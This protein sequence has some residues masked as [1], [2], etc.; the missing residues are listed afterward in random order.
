[1]PSARRRR[2]NLPC[3]HGQQRI[4]SHSN[5]Q[6]TVY[7]MKYV[8]KTAKTGLNCRRLCQCFHCSHV[9]GDWPH[10]RPHEPRGAGRLFCEATRRR[11]RPTGPRVGPRD[12]GSRSLEVPRG[13]VVR[14]A[15]RRGFLPAAQASCR[16]FAPQLLSCFGPRRRTHVPQPTRPHA[17]ILVFLN[18]RSLRMT[19]D[20]DSRSDPSEPGVHV[21][22]V[23]MRTMYSKDDAPQSVTHASG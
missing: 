12:S 9:N 15:F 21:K 6:P 8:L 20:P 4:R 16:T 10:A 3:S 14:H 2:H 18:P 19:F 22:L 23:R 11:A 7:S 13:S 1:M 5:L 17:L